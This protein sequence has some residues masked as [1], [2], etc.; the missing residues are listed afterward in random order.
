M[1]LSSATPAVIE[2]NGVTHRHGRGRR[3]THALRECSFRVPE[4]S[5]CALVGPNGAGKTT[6]LR[7]VAGLVR[8]TSGSVGVLGA[9]PGT[10]RDR[11]GY[12]DQSQPLHENLSVADTL[13]MG[14]RL[15]SGH[16]DARYAA[17]I[18]AAGGLDPQR[19]V[20]GLSGG[21]RTRLSLALALGK[22]PE[23]LLLD[24]PMAGLD[25]LA[26]REL[27]GVLLADAAERGT[28]VLLSSHVVAELAEACDHLLLIGG[29]RVRLGGSIDALLAAHR[30]VTS[31]DGDLSPH[32]VIE[33]RP[34]GRG[35]TTLIRPRGPVRAAV[36][37]EEPRLEE[38]ILAHLRTPSAPALLLPD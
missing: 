27:M 37:P 2:A 16:W 38:V 24:E 29:G 9:A 31:M 15:N 7:I 6:L 11:V 1:S 26:R 21:Q 35:L 13:T 23:L 3:A 8:P 5:V 17:D 22:R 30:V 33:S 4:G 36:R 19:G 12:L 25:P 34:S 14:A 10:H 18:V 20:R 32:T 28:S